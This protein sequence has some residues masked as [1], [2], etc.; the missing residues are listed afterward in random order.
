[1]NCHVHKLNLKV[2]NIQ[3]INPKLADKQ[4][5][6]HMSRLKTYDSPCTISAGCVN[7]VITHTLIKY[8]TTHQLNTK[9]ST[10]G[11]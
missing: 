11:D 2:R 7:E 10:G 3:L 1:M 9:S 5:E 8:Y 4:M 6:A